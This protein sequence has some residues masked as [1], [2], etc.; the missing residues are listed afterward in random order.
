M[1]YPHLDEVHLHSEFCFIAP[2]YWG[3]TGVFVLEWTTDYWM[4]YVWQNKFEDTSCA[5][6]Q[7]T[8]QNEGGKPRRAVIKLCGTQRE[9]SASNQAAKSQKDLLTWGRRLALP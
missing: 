4:R 8:K 1:I 3:S 6:G 2:G 9:R 7:Q 5:F